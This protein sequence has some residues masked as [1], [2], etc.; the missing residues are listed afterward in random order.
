MSFDVARVDI[1]EHT[2]IIVV[3]IAK[4]GFESVAGGI[5]EGRDLEHHVLFVCDGG[6]VYLS[7]LALVLRHLYGVGVISGGRGVAS[8]DPVHHRFEVHR[9]VGILVCRLLGRADSAGENL[10]SRDVADQRDYVNGVDPAVLVE[11][12]RRRADVRA[13]CVYRITDREDYIRHTDLSVAVRVAVDQ[14]VKSFAS[15]RGDHGIGGNALLAGKLCSV[16]SGDLYRRAVVEVADKLFCRHV[17]ADP[18]NITVFGDRELRGVRK[19]RQGV[20]VLGHDSRYRQ[21]E[22]DCRKEHC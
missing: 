21:P 17:R 22:H 16:G 4:L 15:A 13:A 18:G 6:Y 7:G 9:D 12:D 20:S 19:R 5:G 8:S 10:P 2:H 14:C 3:L 11:V 1:V